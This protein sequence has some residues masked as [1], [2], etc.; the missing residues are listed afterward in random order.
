MCSSGSWRTAPLP[1][2]GGDRVLS[3]TTPPCS[4]VTAPLR[5]TH[6]SQRG[7][8]SSEVAPP[9]TRLDAAQGRALEGLPESHLLPPARRTELPLH[10]SPLLADR[11]LR[12]KED[13]LHHAAAGQDE[14]IKHAKAAQTAAGG[15]GCT[16]PPTLAQRIRHG[17][18]ARGAT[19]GTGSRVPRHHQ[20]GSD[21]SGDGLLSPAPGHLLSTHH[22]TGLFVSRA[23]LQ[24]AQLL[25]PGVSPLT[26]SRWKPP[27]SL[28]GT[29]WRCPS[30]EDKGH[31][32]HRALGSP[33]SQHVTQTNHHPGSGCSLCR[34]FHPPLQALF[35]PAKPF[36]RQQGRQ[37]R[38]PSTHSCHVL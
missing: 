29:G 3:E 10:S 31:S 35:L 28:P 26:V 21:D 24:A 14:T 9:S 16:H 19:S 33:K 8:T 11:D 5:V 12:L 37:P 4:P 13:A 30:S 36:T 38:V 2:V 22:P 6:W 7:F 23:A 34:C 27:R 1:K 32:T 25:S 15:H 18:G 20:A 17:P